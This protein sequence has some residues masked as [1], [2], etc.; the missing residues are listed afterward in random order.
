MLS[1]MLSEVPSAVQSAST[2]MLRS[3]QARLQGNRLEEL[4]GK[5]VFKVPIPATLG[6]G[7]ELKMI[8]A[9]L[10]RPAIAKIRTGSI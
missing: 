10:E 2:T 6:C 8:A 5:R 1:V 4:F 7:G 3:M 9:I